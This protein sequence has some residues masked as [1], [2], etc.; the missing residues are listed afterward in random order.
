[1]SKKDYENTRRYFGNL[2]YTHR[3]EKK[4]ISMDTL[5]NATNLDV[6]NLSRIERGEQMP[7]STTIAKIIEALDID[8]IEFHKNFCEQIKIDE[9]KK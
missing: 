5:A 8:P 1:M 4:N 3:R 9:L 7:E 6:N 2:M